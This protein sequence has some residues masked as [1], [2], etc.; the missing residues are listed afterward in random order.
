[1]SLTSLQI[2]LARR[3]FQLWLL[4]HLE[5]GI[6]N[7]VSH[8]LVKWVMGSNHSCLMLPVNVPQLGLYFLLSNEKILL[9]RKH[10]KYTACVLGEKYD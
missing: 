9:K 4:L 3:I 10:N 8:S 2:Q 7:N 6:D 1:M 5:M